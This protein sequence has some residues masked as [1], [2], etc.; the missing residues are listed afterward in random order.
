MIKR[1]PTFD[2]F[3][4][5]SS[6]TTFYP[7]YHGGELDFSKPIYFNDE[8]IIAQSYGKVDHEYKLVL[9]NVVVIDFSD[10]EGWWL[11]EKSAKIQAKKMNMTLDDFD[12]YKDYKEIRDVKTDH[13]VRAA[14]DKGYDGI[15]FKN[16]MD[17][18]SLPIKGN[19]WIRSM[20]IVV[21]KPNNSNIKKIK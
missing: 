3:L 15:I 8:R 7:M 21:L 4:N 11:P 20:D 16:I 19:K 10:A 18:G 17:A 1:I 14:L 2:E 9:K 12:K 13:F 5:E 6:K